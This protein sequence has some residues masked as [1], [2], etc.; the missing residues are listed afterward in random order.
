M[1]QAHAPHISRMEC[2]ASCGAPTST[3]RQPRLLDRIGPV[4]HA[5]SM[6]GRHLQVSVGSAGNVKCT[7]GVQLSRGH[8]NQ[9]DGRSHVVVSRLRL[10]Q[11]RHCLVELTDCGAARHVAAHRKLLGGNVA[12]PRHLP[13]VKCQNFNAITGQVNAIAS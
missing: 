8:P 7:G 13:A 6:T 1:C 9:I 12:L 5:F 2:M 10:C 3:V 11:A 4:G